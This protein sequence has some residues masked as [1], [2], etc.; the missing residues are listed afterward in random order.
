MA[1]QN[2]DAERATKRIRL[3]DGSA[4]TT[5]AATSENQAAMGI[6]KIVET[7]TKNAHSKE[8]E[9]GILRWVNEENP[10]FEGIL[11]QR[12][13]TRIDLTFFSASKHS[14]SYPSSFAACC[15]ITWRHPDSQQ[16]AVTQLSYWTAD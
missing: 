12:Y 15:K 13:K 16:I 7:S 10:G 6:P 14:L 1:A 4:A 8:R 3:E 2:G 11:K 5:T 9:V